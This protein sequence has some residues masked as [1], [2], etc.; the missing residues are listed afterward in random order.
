MESGKW[1]L[2]DVVIYLKSELATLKALRTKQQIE[3]GCIAKEIDALEI[4]IFKIARECEI[5]N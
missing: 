3:L 5:N 1:T 4:R 2:A